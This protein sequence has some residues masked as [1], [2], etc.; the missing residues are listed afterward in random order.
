MW[1]FIKC[2]AGVVCLLPCLSGATPN[3]IDSGDKPLVLFDGRTVLGRIVAPER[4]S[5]LETLA[6]QQITA[7][8]R[9]VFGFEMP[10]VK[11]RDTGD[12]SNAVVIGT[13]V[14]NS[15]LSGFA[16]PTGA[17]DEEAFVIRKI[18]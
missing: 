15:A 6:I 5:A 14:T 4:P 1:K 9:S 3:A 12:L 13:P 16:L 10:V 18:S 8:T 17:A 11:A 2:A 7:T